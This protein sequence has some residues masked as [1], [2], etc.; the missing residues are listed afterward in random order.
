MKIYKPTSKFFKN[1]K[2]TELASYFVNSEWK[3]YMQTYPKGK[4]DSDGDELCC[5]DEIIIMQLKE[6]L[7]EKYITEEDIFPFKINQYCISADYGVVKIAQIEERKECNVYNTY[8]WSK[9]YHYGSPDNL[10]LMNA[11]EI[12]RYIA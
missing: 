8:W 3:I 7:N 9:I 12:A 11:E 2:D 10:R 4:I 6:A 5:D 1:Y